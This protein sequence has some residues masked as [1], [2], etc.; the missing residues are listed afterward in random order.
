MTDDQLTALAIAI[1]WLLGLW[2][3]YYVLPFLNVLRR[4][5]FPTFSERVEARFRAYTPRSAPLPHPLWANPPEPL[6][7]NR[8]ALTLPEAVYIAEEPLDDP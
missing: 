3:G 2:T 4:R 7:G 8:R 5:W 1:A 6:W